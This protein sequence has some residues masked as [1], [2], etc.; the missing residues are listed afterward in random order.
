MSLGLSVNCAMKILISLKTIYKSLDCVCKRVV[1]IP[2]LENSIYLLSYVS[3]SINR[4]FWILESLGTSDG[5]G[6]GFKTII[7]KAV[8]N[9]NTYDT[10]NQDLDEDSTSSKENKNLERKVHKKKKK[11]TALISSL[12]I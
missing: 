7:S 10:R 5:T 11:D 9:S 4:E 1:I 3:D 8:W 6:N 2:L 12:D